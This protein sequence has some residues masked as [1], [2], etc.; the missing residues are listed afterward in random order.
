MERVMAEF[1]HPFDPHQAVNESGCICGRHRS[2]REHEYETQRMLQ[3]VTVEHESKRYDGVLACTVMSKVYPR[4]SN[5]R[6]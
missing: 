6:V 3:C 5:R 1:D 2:Q 4:R